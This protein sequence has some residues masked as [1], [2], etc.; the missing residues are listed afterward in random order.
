MGHL[1]FAQV[2]AHR[3][4]GLTAANDKRVYRLNRHAQSFFDHPT[5]SAARDETDL[6]PWWMQTGCAIRPLLAL[7]SSSTYQRGPITNLRSHA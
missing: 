6:G 7:T 5:A 4:P 2:F 1:A 3:H